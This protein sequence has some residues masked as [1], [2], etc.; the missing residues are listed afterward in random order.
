MAISKEELFKKMSELGARVSKKEETDPKLLDFPMNTR[1]KL[2]IFDAKMVEPVDLHMDIEGSFDGKFVCPNLDKQYK[3]LTCPAC[4]LEYTRMPYVL[5][6]GF[7]PGHGLQVFQLPAN[8]GEET[9]F[10]RFNAYYYRADLR[11]ICLVIKKTF[12]QGSPNY[13]I[14]E[15]RH[16]NPE[17]GMKEFRAFSKKYRDGEVS[18][19]SAFKDATIEIVEDIPWV[20][21]RFVDFG[22]PFMGK[23]AA[24]LNAKFGLNKGGVSDD[25]QY[26]SL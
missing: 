2:S 23:N 19:A 9:F 4:R 24:A 1:V 6:L 17:L 7:Q 11:S 5:G 26:E 25:D 12:G 10:G 3:V 21:D 13:E 14:T 22:M 15:W 8:F 18:L 16:A 20:Q